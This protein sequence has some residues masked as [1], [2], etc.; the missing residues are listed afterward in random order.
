VGFG[1]ED[2]A[3]G[4]VAEVRIPYSQLRFPDKPVHVWGVNIHAAHGR[5]E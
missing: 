4:W 1:G 2:H 5:N 3:D